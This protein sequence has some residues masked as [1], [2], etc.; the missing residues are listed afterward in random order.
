MILGATTVK[1]MV[2]ARSTGLRE[3]A[4]A[5]TTLIETIRM[6]NGA[7]PLWYLHLRRLATSCRALGVPI[8]ADL[9]TPEGGPDRVHRLLVSRRGVVAGER[10]VGEHGAG[11]V[12]HVEAGRI[13]RI[14]TR[15]VDRGPSSTAR[16]PRPRRGAPTTRCC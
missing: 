12:G 6:R 1:A 10:T 13:A 15:V 7:A 4:G 5:M 11:A 14:P 8:P 9:P 3:E 2:D 16:W